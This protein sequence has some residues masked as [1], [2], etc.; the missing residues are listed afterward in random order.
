MS[1]LKGNTNTAAA[2]FNFGKGKQASS[3][4]DSDSL[5]NPKQ[6]LLTRNQ[7][8]YLETFKDM[9]ALQQQKKKRTA[10]E[11]ISNVSSF[12]LLLWSAASS[13]AISSIP[14][15]EY[16]RPKNNFSR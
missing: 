7:A 9:S 3:E 6:A 10:L 11:N 5:A 8:K 13:T 4:D 15:G 12:F 2:S 16:K 1:K 14:S